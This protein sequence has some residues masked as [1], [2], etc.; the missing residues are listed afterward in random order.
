M[1]TFKKEFRQTIYDILEYTDYDKFIAINGIDREI[2]RLSSIDFNIEQFYKFTREAEELKRMFR[3]VYK[4]ALEKTNKQTYQAMEGFVHDLNSICPSKLTTINLGTDTSKEG[5]MITK[6]ILRTIEEGIGENKVA[7]SPKVVFK[8]KRGKNFEEKDPNYDLLKKACQIAV[9]TDNISFSFLDATFN[10]N[11]YKEGDYNT[12]VS[13]FEDGS[14]VI[15]NEVDIDKRTVSGRGI[16]STTVINLTR[17]AIKHM[18]NEKEFFKE[19]ELKMDLVKDQMLERFEIQSNKRVYNFPFLMRQNIWL[20]SEKLREDDKIKRVLKQGI[21]QIS[22]TGLNE[23]ITAL[24]KETRF[25]KSKET[26]NIAKKI[27]TTM[28]EKV[29]EYSRKYNIT[30]VLSENQDNE[31]NKQFLEFDRVIFGKIKNVTDKEKYTSGFELP[32]NAT[33][34]EK[35]QTESAFHELTNGGHV[36]KAKLL[37]KNIDGV[38]NILKEAQKRNI[39]YVKIIK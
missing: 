11:F 32:E 31:I 33:I 12:E 30:F 17:I 29:E 39:G 15:D 6:N 10:E 21:L 23:C 4:K 3:I 19:L 7:I 2:D 20:D 1:K 8:I 28:N 27:V 37:D 25:D 34:K 5:R 14:R 18:E 9:K 35:L 16:V 24:T 13:Y 38:L 22:F 26:Y 36:F